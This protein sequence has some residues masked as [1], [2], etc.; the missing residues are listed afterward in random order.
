MAASGALPIDIYT[1]AGIDML[2]PERKRETKLD[3]GQKP[4]RL[5]GARMSTSFRRAGWTSD[6]PNV[7]KPF[8]S[9]RRW[10]TAAR[11]RQLGEARQGDQHR[12]VDGIFVKP[13]G[14]LFLARSKSGPAPL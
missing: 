14:D 6:E 10:R 7:K 12:L 1:M 3:I 4:A 5:R 11:R 2:A 13:A 9:P 8:F